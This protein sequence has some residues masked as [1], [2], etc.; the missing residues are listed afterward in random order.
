MA[1]YKGIHG[2][3]IDAVSS[4]PPSPQEGQVWYNT[5]SGVLKY[6]TGSGAWSGGGNLGSGRYSPAQWGTQTASMITGGGYPSPISTSEIYDGSTWSASP[7]LIAARTFNF[8]GVGTTSSAMVAAGNVG[9][10]SYATMNSTE[11]W[12]NTAW[13]TSPATTTVSVS[14][15]SCAGLKPSALGFGG[16]PST[17]SMSWNDTS[18]AAT[19]SMSGTG[20]REQTGTGTKTAA[21]SFGGKVDPPFLNK[22][23]TWNDTCWT[24]SPGTLLAARYGA[25]AFGTTTSA[26]VT[27]GYGPGLLNST[28]IWNGTSMTAG[29]VYPAAQAT[30]PGCGTSSLGLVAGGES[31]STSDSNTTTEWSDPVIKTVTVS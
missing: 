10:P 19:N 25:A 5:D 17:Q 11:T 18:W 13:S 9:A 14:G 22:I 26:V 31:P 15:V 28:E 7:S 24:T 30:M 1:T 23:E 16:G 3:N 2:Y 20:T 6:A 27:G 21:I 29:A 8:I 4:D 12:N